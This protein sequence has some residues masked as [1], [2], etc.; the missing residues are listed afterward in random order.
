MCALVKGCAN[1]TGG[2]ISLAF[3]PMETHP[4]RSTPLVIIRTKEKVLHIAIVATRCKCVSLLCAKKRMGHACMHAPQW[5]LASQF[6]SYSLPPQ[7]KKLAIFR[8][9]QYCNFR[10][11]DLLVVTALK[12]QV[13]IIE[14]AWVL[15]L[16]SLR[17][18][19]W[20]T[21]SDP[22]RLELVRYSTTP[23]RLRSRNMNIIEK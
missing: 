16:L 2:R 3:L 23:D 21:T 18:R 8:G 12:F 14:I 10:G 9:Q 17:S 19:R 1:A 20:R 6:L 7:K 5:L 4:R 13:Q 22:S 11:G 15:R